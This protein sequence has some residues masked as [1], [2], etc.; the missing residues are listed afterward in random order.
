MKRLL[1]LLLLIASTVM[2][3]KIPGGIVLTDRD[4]NTYD[5]DAILA[6]GKSIVVHKT[7]KF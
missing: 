2:A 1:V 5:L 4:G 7:A 3:A 6:Q